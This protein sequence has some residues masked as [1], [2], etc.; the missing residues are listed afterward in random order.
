MS[1]LPWTLENVRARA[2]SRHKLLL[3]QAFWPPLTA[4]AVL[5]FAVALTPPQS[6]V[7]HAR[8]PL[9]WV[10]HDLGHAIN[11]VWIGIGLILLIVPSLV[12][13]F[14]HRSRDPWAW[15]ALDA[16]LLDFLFV[17]ALGKNL[18]LGLSR[19]NL[20]VGPDHPLRP[21]F[22]SGHA[23]MGFLLA[24]LIWRRFPRLGP[25]WFAVAALIGWS[26]VESHAH[27]PYQVIAG[28]IYGCALGALVVSR[29][30]G[31]LLPRILLPDAAL[32]AVLKPSGA[33]IRSKNEV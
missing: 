19:P 10:A 6:R 23:A 32:R 27:F 9:E 12:A 26:R 11:S 15:R 16:I 13:R 29:R 4:L 18:F 3:L 30:A 1:L 21:G 17:D 7:V 8:T 28:A 33:S 5:I 2:P 22:P 24:F 14:K 25:L 20:R 31:V